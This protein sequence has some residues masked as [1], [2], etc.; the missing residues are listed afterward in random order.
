MATGAG[1]R[2]SLATRWRVRRAMP[3]KGPRGVAWQPPPR[4]SGAPRRGRQIAGGIWHFAGQLVEAQETSPW[5]I[6]A[7]SIPFEMQLHGMG[8]LDDVMAT[9]DRAAIA[10][11]RG[12]VV[13]WVQRYGRGTGPGWT[14]PLTGRRL[15]RW[16]SHAPD[17]LQSLRPADQA[18]FFESAYAQAGLLRA[19]WKDA[20]AGLPRM[21]ALT[22]LLYAGLTLDGMAGLCDDAAA[23]LTRA[24]GEDVGPDGGIAARNPEALLEVATLLGWSIE[25]L[26]ASDHAVPQG[27]SEAQ[28]RIIPTLRALRH[29]DGGLA[30]FHGGGRGRE[31]RLDRVL[32]TSGIRARNDSGLAM[33]FVPIAHGRTTLIVDAEAPPTGRVSGS[34]AASTLAFE[35]T[36]G[37]SPVIV[38]CGPGGPFGPEWHR[39]GR[40]TASHSTLILDGWS[41]S[42]IGPLIEEGGRRIAP[43]IQTPKHVQW[44][45]S[46]SRRSSTAM[47]SHDGYVPS[48]GLTHLRR[49]ILSTDGRLLEGED[50]LRAIKASD[51]ERFDDAMTE[52]KLQGFPYKV[53]F[54][55]H[56]D[57]QAELDLGGRA[58]SITLASG[59]VWVFRPGRDIEMSVDPSVHLEPGRLK[60]RAATQVV[61][62]DRV[63]KYA[64]TIDWTLTRAQEAVDLPPSPAEGV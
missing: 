2:E 56:P 5:E 30:R 36:S 32:A 25:A 34:A 64:A 18:A 21:E 10:R 44:Q 1:F 50:G 46:N 29:A 43:L 27:L 17:L 3:A 48:H 40:A 19:H 22:G 49:L 7:P 15:L 42:R 39:A 45:R 14:M 61:L 23:A 37:G 6:E 24:M 59:E 26:T 55:L 47:F 57:A 20:P 38:N 41:S 12:W 16:I 62:S 31:G 60:P 58:V 51:K 52:A 9:G 33:G 4:G 11:V 53:R 8:W 13:E 28:A 63:V 35:M 54:H